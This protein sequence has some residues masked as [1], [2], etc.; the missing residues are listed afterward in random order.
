MCFD[1]KSFPMRVP[2]I[3]TLKKLG[4]STVLYVKSK[5]KYFIFILTLVYV[6]LCLII[7]RINNNQRIPPRKLRNGPQ[8]EWCRPLALK[9][10]PGPVVALASFPGKIR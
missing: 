5:W 10:T 1:H 8:I 4:Q 9:A 6:L 3:Y 7:F 2:C